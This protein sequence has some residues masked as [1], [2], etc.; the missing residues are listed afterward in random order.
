MVSSLPLSTVAA[1]AGT[2]LAM[3]K[4]VLWAGEWYSYCTMAS[5]GS[6]VAKLSIAVL[7]HIP[8]QVVDFVKFPFWS[9]GHDV[10]EGVG[11]EKLNEEVWAENLS[12][13]FVN[14]NVKKCD[15][16]TTHNNNCFKPQLRLCSPREDGSC[17]MWECGTWLFLARRVSDLIARVQAR[18]TSWASQTQTVGCS[19]HRPRRPLY[20]Y[21]DIIIYD[22]VEVSFEI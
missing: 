9:Q 3:L 22:L 21:M 4:S 2:C 18:Q 14:Q 7:R 17:G 11:E 12:K 20:W 6:K 13:C 16:T 8:S 10:I 19:A 5:D 15:T 1:W